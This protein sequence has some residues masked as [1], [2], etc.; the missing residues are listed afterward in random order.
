LPESE[1]EKTEKAVE[2]R[3]GGS[4]RRRKRRRDDRE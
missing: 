2:G 1:I 3:K 4:A